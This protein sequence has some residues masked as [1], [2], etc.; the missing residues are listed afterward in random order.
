ME[1]DDYMD[2]D[3]ISVSDVDGSQDSDAS[4]G[5]DVHD[6]LD[7][8]RMNMASKS[9]RLTMNASQLMNLS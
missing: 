8:F 4:A 2:D 1:E 6:A 3:D 5:N 7:A 9:S